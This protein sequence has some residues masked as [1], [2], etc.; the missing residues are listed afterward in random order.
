MIVLD[1]S[2]LIAFLDSNDA[3][4]D[5]ATSLFV[6][7]AEEDLAAS[8]VTLGEV[9]VGPVRAGRTP[10][11]LDALHDLEIRTLPLPE[12]PLQLAEM[13]VRTG[14]R[15]PDCCVLLAALAT[16]GSLATFDTAQ[17]EAATREGIPLSTSS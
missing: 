7:H 12:L 11:V 9:L 5:R 1:A 15:M 6:S 4:H 14:L 8:V 10:Q 17:A 13:R 2:V 16:S 3:H